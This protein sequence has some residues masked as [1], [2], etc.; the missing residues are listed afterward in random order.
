[1]CLRYVNEQEDKRNREDL[2]LLL[3]GIL[4]L[5]RYSPIILLGAY[6][7]S[8]RKTASLINGRNK[9]AGAQTRQSLR[10]AFTAQPQVGNKHGAFAFVGKMRL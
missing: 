8:E 5:Y 6:P 9:C 1:M 4:T 7:D 2:L 10:E 3:Y